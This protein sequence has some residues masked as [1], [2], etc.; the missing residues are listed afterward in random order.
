[1]S[2][3]LGGVKSKLTGKLA[4]GNETVDISADH[5]R[6]LRAVTLDALKP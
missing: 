3:G 1:M 2:P 4:T 5:P 6:L